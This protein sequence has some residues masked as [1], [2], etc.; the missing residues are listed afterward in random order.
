MKKYLMGVDGGGTKTDV[1]L[2]TLEGQIVAK[3]SGGSSSMAGQLPE[4]AMRELKRTICAAF[5]SAG[6]DRSQVAGYYA[7]VSGA[8][9]PKHQVL[10][11]SFFAELMPGITGD[12]GSD[13]VNALSAGIAMQDGTIAIAGTGSSVHFRADGTFTRVGGWGYILGDEG[14]GFDLGQRAL[15]AVLRSV[16][17]RIGPTLLRELC[18]AQMGQP[19]DDWIYWV[20]HQDYKTELAAYAPL[21][22]QAAQQGD[23][24]ALEELN[25]ATKGMAC[26]I[27]TA[28]KRGGSPRV[29]MGGSLWKNALYREMVKQHSGD[30]V[31]FIQAKCPPVCGA[32]IIAADM[33]SGSDTDALLDTMIEQ[34]SKE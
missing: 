7:G 13:S 23:E 9:L 6:I 19:L 29:V 21:L 22:L 15:T 32:V 1:L 12:A 30:M 18:E 5:S 11:R 4:K 14:S 24:I 10:Y 25:Q 31:E 28:I 34:Y 2:C 26:A 8:G 16:D 17:Q 33:V 3:A 27:R 20:Y